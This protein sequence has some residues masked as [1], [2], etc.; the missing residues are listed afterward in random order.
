MRNDEVPRVKFV[1]RLKG[2][3][4]GVARSLSRGT[5]GGIA[6]DAMELADNL[7]ALVNEDWDDD[8]TYVGGRVL[9]GNGVVVVAWVWSNAWAGCPRA[10]VL[11]WSTSFRS[12]D[13]QRPALFHPFPFW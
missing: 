3:I 9:G 12:L 10:W 8:V 11:V 6:A 1:P 2:K 4:V 7:A 13:R 5:R